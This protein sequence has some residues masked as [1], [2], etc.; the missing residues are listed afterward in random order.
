M[1]NNDQVDFTISGE[2]MQ[3]VEIHLDSEETVIAEVGA[4]MYMHDWISMKTIFWD[5]SDKSENDGFFWKL[6]GAGK[7]LLTGENIFTTAFTN[8]SSSPS[9]VAFASPYPGKIIPLSLAEHSGKIVCQ[10]DSFLCAAKGVEVGIELQRNLG[11]G[12]FWWE[13]FIMQKLEGDGMVFMHAGGHIIERELQSWEILRVDTG[14][15][16]AYTKD[17]QY[18]I[19]MVKG[20]K[21]IMFWWE[22]IFY[23]T[24]KGPGKIWLQTLPISRLASKIFSYAPQQSWSHKEEGN[25]LVNSALWGVVNMMINK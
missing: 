7:R 21:N 10:K 8:N 23:A 11:T 12:L 22:G 18:D 3:L 1:K 20:I 15:V 24:L 16:V 5:G 2:E 17:I 4:F 25:E 14:C 13:G 19:E 9:A 6:L